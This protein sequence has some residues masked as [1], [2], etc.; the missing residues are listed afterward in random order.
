MSVK[1]KNFL[2]LFS[3]FWHCFEEIS[4]EAVIGDL[5]DRRLW[6]FVDGHDRLRVLHAGQVLNRARNRDG[7]VQ[8]LSNKIIKVFFV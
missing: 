3:E 6:I 1:T 7:D 4:D 8:I 2:E 5:E